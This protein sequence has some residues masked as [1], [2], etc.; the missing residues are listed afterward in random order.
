MSGKLTKKEEIEALRKVHP[1]FFHNMTPD[2]M[3][4]FSKVEEWYRKSKQ[5]PPLGCKRRESPTTNIDTLVHCAKKREHLLDHLQNISRDL[6]AFI[7]GM[8]K[9]NGPKAPFETLFAGSKGKP[10]VKPLDTLWP[11]SKKRERD[12]DEED[13][14]EEEEGEEDEETED[15]EEEGTEEKDEENPSSIIYSNPEVLE[16]LLE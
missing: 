8:M 3:A 15:E 4:R 10:G 1:Y 12:E 5:D 9:E 11:R 7:L 16:K 6:D 2:R 14:E 13:E